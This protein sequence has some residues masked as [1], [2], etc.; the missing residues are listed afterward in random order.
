DIAPGS[1][2]VVVGL[3]PVGVMALQCAR[4]FGPA[5]IFAVD[6]VP[7]RLARA[8]RYGAEPVDAR[9]APGSVQ[10]MEATAGMG[11]HS[12]IEAVGADATVTDAVMCAAVG[13]TVSVV[14]VNLQMALPFPMAIVFLKSLTL[15][16]VF[17]PIPGT[18]R[19]LLPLV[20]AGHLDLAGTFTHQLNLSD[21]ARAYEL[22]D[23]RADGVLK[24]LL[25]PKG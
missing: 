17:A 3:G 14:G 12:V 25:N 2:V 7:E 9:V 11:A 18:W 8:E 1:T 10:V 16:A 22:F 4:L 5:R 21:V 6:T 13:G 15:R 19:D 24:V 20:Q 23:S